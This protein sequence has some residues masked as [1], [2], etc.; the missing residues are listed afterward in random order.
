MRIALTIEGQEGVTWDEWLAIAGTAEAH[1]VESLFRSDHYA[2]VLSEGRSSLDAWATIAGLAAVTHRIR[3]GTMVSPVTF[4][5]PSV[6]ARMVTTAD[7]I[8]GGR[9]ELGMGTGW[10]ELEHRREGFPFHDVRTRFDL[11][12]EQVEV[13]VRSWTETA[14]DFVGDHY[15]LSAQ[16]ALPR[17]VQTPHPPLLLG[18]SAK[19]RS[20]A[21]AARFAQEYNTPGSSA[22]EC[23]ARREALDR[24]CA[25]VGR[26]P[27]SLPLSVVAACVIGETRTEV[28]MRLRSVLQ[29][30]DDD[31][32]PEELAASKPQWLIGTVVEIA[33]RIETYRAAGVERIYLQLLDHRDLAAIALIGDQ[34][35]PRVS[36]ARTE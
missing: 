2:A 15:S 19:P 7:H 1:G 36:T 4:R 3:L 14:F 6:L 20:A 25:D 24:A 5:H 34:L 22:D 31:R 16:T 26:D 28:D 13:V 9:V 23:R 18:G 21:L 11:F 27:A 29:V 17:P 30:L 10:Y 35:L 12:A 33:E 8:S 32:H